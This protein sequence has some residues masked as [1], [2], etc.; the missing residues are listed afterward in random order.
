[1]SGLD[2]DDIQG[3]IA[4]ALTEMIR[5]L[6]IVPLSSPSADGLTPCPAQSAVGGDLSEEKVHA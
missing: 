4:P 2:F 6:R 5:L 3:D 1:M